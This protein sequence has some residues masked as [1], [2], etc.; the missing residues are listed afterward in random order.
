MTIAIVDHAI[1]MTETDDEREQGDHG[2]A[3]P[4]LKVVRRQWKAAVTRHLNTLQRHIAEGDVEQVRDRLNKVKVTFNELEYA[5]EAFQQT[6]TT[7]AEFDQSESWFADAQRSYISSIKS[8]KQWLGDDDKPVSVKSKVTTVTGATQ[9]SSAQS[10]NTELINLLNIPKLEI[11]KFDGNPKEFQSFV[12]IFD[13]G[14]TSKVSDDQIKLTRLL[15]YTTGPAKAAIRNCALIGGRAGY[16]QARDILQ[17]RFGIEHLVSRNILNDLIN[18]KSVSKPNDIRQLADD[19]AMAAAVLK[20][21]NLSHEIDNQNSVLEILQR[22]L[23]AIQ[24]KRRNRAL[25]VKR[26]SGSYPTFDYF[27]EFMSKIASDWSDPV[28]GG[29]ALKPFSNNSPRAKTSYVNTFSAGS[30]APFPQKPQTFKPCVSCGQSHRLIY[31]LVFKTMKPTARLQLAREKRLCY[32]CLMP[33]H[34]VALCR[35]KSVC[36]VPDCG[37]RHSKFLHTDIITGNGNTS[38]SVATGGAAGDSTDNT[39]NCGSTCAFGTSVYLPIVQLSVNGEHVHALLDTG[40]TNTF[41]SLRLA[42]SLSLSGYNHDYVIKTV[43]R[44]KPTSSQVVKINVHLLLMDHTL[45]N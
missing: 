14:V 30:S 22:V 33:N 43:S 11:D 37:K 25:E 7:D 21:L 19:L 4:D 20:S 38:E 5:H 36:S 32:N 23:K 17:K 6:F 41:V 39:V 12:A 34:V 2:D 18:G 27:V 1:N 10:H 13:E 24:S 45:R 40:S 28:Y 35:N 9:S 8:A 44:I 15:Q 26:D 3:Q 42:Q 29:D 16:T 31:C